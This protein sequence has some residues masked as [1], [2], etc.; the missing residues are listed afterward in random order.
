[1]KKDFNYLLNRI[2]LLEPIHENEDCS[3]CAERAKQFLGM[4]RIITFVAYKD[5]EYNISEFIAPGSLQNQK[6]LYHTVLLVSLNNKKYIVDITSDFKV[7][8]YEDYI[9]TLKDINKLNFRQY[10]G[11]IWNKVIYTLRWNTLP[12]GKDI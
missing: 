3:E 1:M 7:I 10:T 6:W 4:G 12:G 2:S 9:K 11:A 8:K 5:G